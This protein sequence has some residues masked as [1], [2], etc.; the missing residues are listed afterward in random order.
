MSFA[1]KYFV[2]PVEWHLCQ[3]VRMMLFDPTIEIC[4]HSVRSFR[5]SGY[6]H[7]HTFPVNLDAGNM[8]ARCQHCFCC[9]SHVSFLKEARATHLCNLVCYVV[10]RR[11]EVSEAHFMCV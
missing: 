3:D 1:P 4:I 2:V 9:A 11:S 7:D 10:F 8:Q 6:H 5:V